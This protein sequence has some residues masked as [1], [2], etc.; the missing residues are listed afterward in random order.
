[1]QEDAA[2]CGE[3]IERLAP[4]HRRTPLYMGTLIAKDHPNSLA[5]CD[6]ILGIFRPHCVQFLRGVPIWQKQPLHYLFRAGSPKL[7]RSS[8]ICC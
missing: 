7:R 5:A 4:F 1:M 3:R 6:T 8:G 2:L